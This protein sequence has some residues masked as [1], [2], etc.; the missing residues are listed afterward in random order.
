[1]VED[2]HHSVDLLDL[3]PI[4]WS[5]EKPLNFRDRTEHYLPQEKNRLQETM[6]DVHKFSNTQRMIINEKKTHTVIFNTAIN[7]DF[8]PR[9]TNPDGEI[10]NNL[11]T[12]KLLGIDL[13][14]DQKRG[15][16]F[17]TYI[18]NCINKGYQKLWILRRLSELGVPIEKLLL[19]YKSRREKG[20]RKKQKYEK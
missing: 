19:V 6:N 3:E 10:Y 2:Y 15:I 8:N 13:S 16:N 20:H 9:I 11:E 4:N 7:K 14:T 12:F 17:N 18:Q 5:S 1:M